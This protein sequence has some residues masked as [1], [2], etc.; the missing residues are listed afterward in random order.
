MTHDLVIRNGTVVDGTGAPG[1]PADVAIHGDRIVAVGTV[2]DKG[3][4]EIDADGQVVA[5]GFVDG[6]THLDAQICWDPL[7]TPVSS[8]GVT[9]VVMGNCG[10]TLAP[11][12]EEEAYLALRSLERA[13]DMSADVLAAGVQWRWETYREYLDAVDALPKGINYAGYVGHSALRTYVMGERAFEEA[14]TDDDLDAMCREV[15][16]AMRA[17]AVGFTTSRSPNHETSDDRPVASRL[18]EWS[19]VQRLVGV[20]GDLGTGV[21]ELANEQH[22]TGEEFDE[23]FGRLRDLSLTTGRP[24]TFVVGFTKHDTARAEAMLRALDTTAAAGGTMI[25]QA[26]PREFQGVLSFQTTLP[27]DR[28]PAWQELRA[29][30]LAEQAVALRDPELRARLVEA[31]NA[32]GYA[33]AIGA[34]ARP[35]DYDWIRVFD[36]PTPPYRTVAEVARERG[37]D[38]VTAM[39][40]LALETDLQLMF[41]Q[42]FGNEDPDM[43]LT[44]LQNPHTIVAT[45]DT[46]AH[47][48]QITDASIPTHLLAYWVRQLE[49]I[50]LEDAVRK[51]TSDAAALWGFADRGVVR[52]GNVADVVV[53]DPA[54]V[55]PAMPEV[56]YD[57][58]TGAR[59]L[60]QGSV[61]IAATI[62]GGEVLLRDG[63]HTGALPG[64][65]LRGTVS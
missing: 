4:R 51:L 21:F 26:N 31:A 48:S 16:D 12:R 3:S 20:L 28:L 53:F 61:G 65:L 55:G 64:R 52:E 42:P 10:F 33:R 50:T 39:I 8:H 15:D 44:V 24:V 38:P 5:P 2:D 29:R 22:R 11:C 19:E 14:A 7:G 27:F 45:S 46:G 34:E 25:G 63:E 59:R 18:A 36:T 54:T 47:V 41:L 43:Q 35:P 49:A 56:A 62:V 9:T 30:P 32:G 40:D 37:V 6:H 17:G 1:F 23:Y 13:E 58:P 60:R 57:F